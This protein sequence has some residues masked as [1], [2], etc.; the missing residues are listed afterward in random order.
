M[1]TGMDCLVMGNYI[2][3]KKDQVKT[4]TVVKKFTLN[5]LVSIVL[6]FEIIYPVCWLSVKLGFF[7]SRIIT[8][9]VLSVIFYFVL[10]PTGLIMKLFKKDVLELKITK[11]TGS[12]WQKKKSTN[13]QINYEKQF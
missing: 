6:N 7:F 3:L 1:N 2:L 12:Y 11:N 10:L 8:M 13:N 5:N 4:K 9:I